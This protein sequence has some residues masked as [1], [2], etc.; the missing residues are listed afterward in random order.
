MK[1]DTADKDEVISANP[2]A[3][4]AE[5]VEYLGG[6]EPDDAYWLQLAQSNY[7]TGK[8]YQEAALTEQWEKNADHFNSKH[9]RRSAYNSRMSKG[10][11]SIFRPLSRAAERSSSAQAAAAFFSNMEII[12]VEPENKNDPEQMFSAK[13]VKKMVEYYLDKKIKWYLT[14]MGAWQD[15]RVYGPCCSF[16]DWRFKKKETEEEIPELNINGTAS[17]DGRTVTTKTTVIEKDEPY[18]NLIPPENL[19]LDPACDWRDPINTSPYVVYLSSM[20]LVD[21]Q[22]KMKSGE[23]HEYSQEDILSASK[24][25]YDAVRQAREGSNRPDK[26][27]VQE[28]TEFKS[29]WVHY[30]FARIDGEEYFYAT[31]GTQFMLTDAVPLEKEYPIGVRPFTYGF[32]VIEAH[33]FSPSSPTEIISGLQTGVNDLANLRIDNIKLALNKRYILRRGAPIDLEALMRSVPGGGVFTDDVEK[34]IKVLDTRDVTGS[35]YR[36]QE[37]LETESN[38]ITGSSMGSAVQNNRNLNQTVGGM[39]MLAEGQSALMDMDTRTFAE[40]WVKP[41]LELLVQNIQMFAPDEAIQALAIEGADKELDYFQRFDFSD[42]EEGGKA[43]RTMTESIMSR[44]LKDKMTVKV[45]VGLG[46]TSPQRKVQTLLGA[47]GAIV[48]LPSQGMNLDEDAIAKEL[49][50][51]SGYQDGNRFIKSEDPNGEQKITQEDLDAAVEQGIQQGTDEV[52]MAQIDAT[53][54]I[55]SGKAELDREIA[56]AT[57]AAKEQISIAELESK[58]QITIRKDQSHRDIEALRAKNSMRELDFKERTGKPG[59]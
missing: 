56:F 34:D 1:T 46:A 58:L 59:I 13:V 21:V 27:D 45:N 4:G 9:F 31:L 51:A 40:S 3:D 42:D 11:S 41:Q 35:S 29:I 38:D 20:P 52:K 39:E 57:L 2:L 25:T 44:V 37:R 5:S 30:N 50:T 47:V 18:I 23:W 32:S 10:R 24:L 17:T 54:T 12:D 28:R 36:E 8:D 15:T 43:K 22:T 33:K 19:I 26:H 6:S 14:L 48:Q 49:F 7:I 53:L 16:T 55:A